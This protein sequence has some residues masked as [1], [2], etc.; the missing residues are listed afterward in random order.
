M[1]CE[2]G[3][4]EQCDQ[5]QQFPL[6]RIPPKDEPQQSRHLTQGHGKVGEGCVALEMYTL[7]F[8]EDI[9]RKK[10]KW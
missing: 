3:E 4:E 9:L 1:G 2:D 8:W 6:G 5:P 10:P 7:I